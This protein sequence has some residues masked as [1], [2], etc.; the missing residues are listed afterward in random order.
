MWPRWGGAVW[1]GV[2]VGPGQPLGHGRP[3][4]LLGV[5]ASHPFAGIRSLLLGRT[6]I[7]V[8]AGRFHGLTAVFPR[9]VLLTL[10]VFAGGPSAERVQPGR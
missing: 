10:H 9:A 3:L 8:A 4:T 1:L 2:L 6:H 5:W 7:R